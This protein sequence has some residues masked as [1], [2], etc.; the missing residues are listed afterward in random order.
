MKIYCELPIYKNITNHAICKRLDYENHT[1]YRLTI[2][3]TIKK[4]VS[5]TLSGSVSSSQNAFYI[6]IFFIPWVL[7]EDQKVTVIE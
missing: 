2:I 3:L 6:E 7:A 4:F 5:G 1:G